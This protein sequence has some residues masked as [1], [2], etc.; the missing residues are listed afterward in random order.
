MQSL[1]RNGGE[2]EMKWEEHVR[3]VTPYTPGEQPQKAGIIK[4]NTNENPYPPA[5]GVAAAAAALDA[6]QMRLYPAFPEKTELMEALAAHYHLGTDQIF[7]GVGSDDVLSMAF[8]TFFSRTGRFFSRISPTLSMMC[9]RRSIK[10][11]MK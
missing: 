5:P 3:R 10:F 2:I 1:R 4:L 8:M 6:D 7:I 9:G 11:L